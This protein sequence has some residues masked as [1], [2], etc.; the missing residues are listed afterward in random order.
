MGIKKI[1]ESRLG[2]S[3]LSTINDSFLLSRDE[4][5]HLEILENMI[6]SKTFHSLTSITSDAIRDMENRDPNSFLPYGSLILKIWAEL[7]K[8]TGL[9]TYYVIYEGKTPERI[10]VFPFLQSFLTGELEND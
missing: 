6:L 7:G 2:S 5:S 4:S 1:I 8:E 10:H 3:L 9:P